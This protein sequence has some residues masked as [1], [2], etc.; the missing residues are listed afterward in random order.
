M[1]PTQDSGTVIDHINI[2]SNIEAVTDV[3]DY[4]YGDHDYVLCGMSPN[5]P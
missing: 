3:A 5:V 1:K 4:Y 2:T